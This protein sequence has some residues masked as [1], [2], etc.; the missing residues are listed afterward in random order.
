MK[1]VISF[2]CLVLIS[3]LLS[4]IFKK[5][6][7]GCGAFS[8]AP[9]LYLAYCDSINIGHVD[10]SIFL[11]GLDDEVSENLNNA[12]MLLLGSSRLQYAFPDNSLSE[13]S[14]INSAVKPYSLGFGHGEQYPFTA[15]ILAAYDV[16]PK[17]WLVNIDP[18]FNDKL[19]DHA[20][21]L[22][23][24]VLHS[25]IK[26]QL[27][28]YMHKLSVLIC[29]SALFESKCQPKLS[30]MRSKSTG[31]WYY[32]HATSQKYAVQY[33]DELDSK[34]DAS[35]LLDYVDS[36]RAFID[37]ND[38]D[39]NCLVFFS[40]PTTRWSQE[41]AAKKITE[42]VGGHYIDIKVANLYTFDRDHL[43]R[44]SAGY[45]RKAFYKLLTP[46]INNCIGR[47]NE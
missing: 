27:K 39:Q 10:H 12:N 35:F 42:E 2:I 11:Y 8:D 23:N 38:V 29:R 24:N 34:I 45:W 13:L 28:I 37:K 47:I 3:F 30:V 26:A 22:T 46:Y 21:E 9:D 43:S 18:F 31:A 6:M 20:I 4:V 41:F 19:S 1:G 33:N 25:Y 17:L 36:A 14:S 16:K 44:E 7:L 15:V 32:E 5:D 40:V